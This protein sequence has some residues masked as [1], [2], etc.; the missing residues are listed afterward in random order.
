MKPVINHRNILQF[1]SVHTNTQ[2]YWNNRVFTVK[3]RNTNTGIVWAWCEVLRFTARGACSNQFALQESSHQGRTWDLLPSGAW[4]RV[5]CRRAPTFH[6][7]LL[8]PSSTWWS[9]QRVNVQHRCTTTGLYGVTSLK[10]VTFIYYT[11]EFIVL[12]S[13]GCG[14]HGPRPLTSACQHLLRVPRWR[15]ALKTSRNEDQLPSD[16]CIHQLHET[17]KNT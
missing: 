17:R 9:R 8:R 3:T 6:T 7:N 10:T 15:L 1:S 13:S 5:V 14:R 2:L 16:C 4:R 11:R 12:F